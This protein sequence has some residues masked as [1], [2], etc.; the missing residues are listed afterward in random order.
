[1]TPAAY[2]EYLLAMDDEEFASYLAG[3]EEKYQEKKARA[4]ELAIA[5]AKTLGIEDI[6]EGM[7]H[8]EDGSGNE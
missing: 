7:D 5:R 8:G 6:T 1:M 4:K 3:E 2:E